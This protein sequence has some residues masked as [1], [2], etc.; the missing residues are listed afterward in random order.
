M[1]GANGPNVRLIVTEKTF[2]DDIEL[3]PTQYHKTEANLVKESSLRRNIAAWNSVPVSHL[4]IT[5]L[6]KQFIG[7]LLQ[8]WSVTLITLKI[9]TKGDFTL[10]TF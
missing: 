4:N 1:N 5:Y 10:H 7:L 9:S 6:F 2:I 3:A 8:K